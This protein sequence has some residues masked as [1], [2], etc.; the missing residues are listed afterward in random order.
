M[1]EQSH[2]RET[3]NARNTIVGRVAASYVRGI[4]IFIW[5]FIYLMVI[6]CEN[7][8][9]YTMRH[10]VCVCGFMCVEECV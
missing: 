5:I 6:I 7:I 4:Y 10:D 1:H 8:I 2:P 3:A 9:C